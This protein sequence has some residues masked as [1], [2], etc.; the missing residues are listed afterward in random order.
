MFVSFDLLLPPPDSSRGAS[1]RQDSGVLLTGVVPA[2]D[3]LTPLLCLW[4]EHWV[5]LRLWCSLGWLES[6]HL[7]DSYLF[8]T[9]LKLGKQLREMMSNAIAGT[10]LP[11]AG[12]A[13][14]AGTA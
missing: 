2:R 13:P 8:Q 5:L 7:G 14:V 1:L 12:S 3:G 9:W 11:H 4:R 10:S 6:I